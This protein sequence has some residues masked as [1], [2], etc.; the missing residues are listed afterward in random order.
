AQQHHININFLKLDILNTNAQELGK[1][2]VII[3]NPPYVLESEKQKMHINVLNYEPASALYVEDHHALLF[4]HKIRQLAAN[5]LNKG[6]RIYLEINETKA[7]EIQNLLES[8]H[9]ENIIIHQ[10]IHSKDRFIS[11]NIS[12]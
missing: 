4:Y 7:K 8:H 3:S 5:C 1:F 2:D 10:D 11:A 6:G 9:F 12:I